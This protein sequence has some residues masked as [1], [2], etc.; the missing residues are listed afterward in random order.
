MLFNKRYSSAFNQ[1]TNRI[2]VCLNYPT[3]A[4]QSK[5]NLYGN[6]RGYSHRLI[7]NTDNLIL[8]EVS[9]T[10][11]PIGY[12]SGYAYRN[13]DL[14]ILHG[15]IFKNFKLLHDPYIHEKTGYLSLGVDLENKKLLVYSDLVI[16]TK[17]IMYYK[18]K[19]SLH[20][21]II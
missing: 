9:F 2:K 18:E 3:F 17:S 8:R 16:L 10:T 7:G 13:A 19:D 11:S 12:I 20:V 6:L 14:K 15:S 1:N 21:P 5:Y 4:K